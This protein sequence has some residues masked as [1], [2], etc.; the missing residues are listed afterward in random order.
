MERGTEHTE[1]NKVQIS[2]VTGRSS[3]TEVVKLSSD[4]CLMTLQ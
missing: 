2:F 3:L 4:T 1:M